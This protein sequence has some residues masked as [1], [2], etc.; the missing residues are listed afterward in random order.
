MNSNKKSWIAP[1]VTRYGDIAKITLNG[2]VANS[3]TLNGPN[4]TAFPP[5]S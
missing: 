5:G 2:N 3:D 1:H 4:N